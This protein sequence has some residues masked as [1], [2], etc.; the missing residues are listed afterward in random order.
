VSKNFELV[1]EARPHT[2][3]ASRRLIERQ[4][5]H[6]HDPSS[7]DRL[8]LQE[9]ETAE[10]GLRA[11]AP[12][13]RKKLAAQGKANADGSY[14][15]RTVEDLKNAISAFGRASDKPATKALIKKRARQL[16]RTDLIPETW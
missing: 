10:L 7:G 5:L 9:Y 3:S 14:P 8:T 6:A 13:E 1:R 16:G 11:V 15:I 2:S 4:E 12:D